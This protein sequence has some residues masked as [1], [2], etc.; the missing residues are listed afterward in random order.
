MMLPFFPLVDCLEAQLLWLLGRHCCGIK[1]SVV[2][3]SGQLNNASS[4]WLSLLSCITALSLTS[5]SLGLHSPRKQQHARPLLQALASRK[6]S[7]R[8]Y[9]S[10]LCVCLQSFTGIAKSSS[11]QENLFL[12]FIFKSIPIYTILSLQISNISF[13]PLN[14][15]CLSK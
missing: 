12:L 6:P 2:F 10:V 8:Q 14:Q 9:I 1:G 7:L 5:C 4:L 15:L 13:Y 11:Y 3:G